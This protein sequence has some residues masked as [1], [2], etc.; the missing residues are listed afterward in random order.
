MRYKIGDKGQ[1]QQN[2]W[3][4]TYPKNICRQAFSRAWFLKMF[5]IKLNV[6]W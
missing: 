5:T 4:Q 3:K 1:R 2:R 6:W